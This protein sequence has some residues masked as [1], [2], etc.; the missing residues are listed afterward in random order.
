MA[1]TGWESTQRSVHP[2]HAPFTEGA[3]S[4]T[5]RRTCPWQSISEALTCLVVLNPP[6]EA[7]SA[8][9][10][11]VYAYRG[12]ALVSGRATFPIRAQTLPLSPV[13]PFRTV[14]LN[15]TPKGLKA[16]ECQRSRCNWDLSDP[17]KEC[18]ACVPRCTFIRPPGTGVQQT[19][20][21]HRSALVLD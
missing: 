12:R 10:L 2:G 1:A 5:W 17:M 14:H 9:T 7:S 6:W 19:V 13:E 15:S 21:Y 20:P 11:L 3:L 18:A 8:F 4:S 16:Q